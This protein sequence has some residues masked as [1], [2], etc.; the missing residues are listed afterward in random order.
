MNPRNI[1]RANSGRLNDNESVSAFLREEGLHP[2][3]LTPQEAAQAGQT[4]D[5]TPNCF[6]QI[7]GHSPFLE[8]PSRSTMSINPHLQFYGPISLGQ[9][10]LLFLASNPILPVAVAQEPF[11]AF[12]QV[13]RPISLI[14]VYRYLGT[15]IRV[16]ILRTTLGVDEWR[17]VPSLVSSL[18]FLRLSPGLIYDA[19]ASAVTCCA[20]AY[21]P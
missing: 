11:F 12:V 3:S 7:F 4:P 9:P 16:P 2:Y 1:P 10:G 17:S 18:W 15:Y 13:S 5:I 21:S 19:F 6:V 20:G 8:R 14:K